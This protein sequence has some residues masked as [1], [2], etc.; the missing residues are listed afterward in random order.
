MSQKCLLKKYMLKNSLF[1]RRYSPSRSTIHTFLF[2]EEF[3]IKVLTWKLSI[4]TKKAKTFL[5]H[6]WKNY[7]EA[8]NS[9]D[10]I[11]EEEKIVLDKLQGIMTYIL[12]VIIQ[13]DDWFGLWCLTPLQQYFIYIVAVSVIGGGHRETKSQFILGSS[14]SWSYDSWIYNYL[15]ISAYH[16]Y[17]CEF[18]PCTGSMCSIQHYVTKFVSDL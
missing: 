7:E 1:P 12:T 16:H 15:C 2:L 13:I 11:I 9:H 3:K 5:G 14:W 8:N 10:T 6:I 17:R 4:I 18:E